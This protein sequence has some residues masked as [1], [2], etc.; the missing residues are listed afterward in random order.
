VRT[1]LAELLDLL[2]PPCCARCSGAVIGREALCEACW[3]ALHPIALDACV[4]CQALPARDGA[5]CAA[6]SSTRDPLDACVAAVWFD[7]E[8]GPWV[9]RVKYPRPGIAGL[10]APARAV[11]LLL[12]ERAAARVPEPPPERIVPVPLHPRAVRRRGFNPAALLARHVAR[13]CRVPWDPV[14]LERVRDTPSQTGLSRIERRRNVAGVFRARRP[15]PRRI[16]LVDD[17]ITTGATLSE[18]ARAAR[19]AGAQQVIGVCVARTPAP[20]AGR[21]P[22]PR[23]SPHK[24]GSRPSEK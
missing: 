24:E 22:G 18:A 21:E 16:W 9:H 6:C 4:R 8:T 2:L 1:L 11:L 17:V 5:R 13:S 15:M 7:G 20:D 10:D 12:A 19:R 14:G 23:R 3:R